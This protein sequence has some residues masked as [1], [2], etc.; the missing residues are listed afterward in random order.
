[1]EV[2]WWYILSALLFQVL[3]QSALVAHNHHDRLGLDPGQLQ[4]LQGY[5]L[6]YQGHQGHTLGHQGNQAHTLGHQGY[7]QYMGQVVG[8][9]TGMSVAGPQVETGRSRPR[10]AQQELRQY[11]ATLHSCVHGST[12]GYPQ[13]STQFFQQAGLHPG[14]GFGEDGEDGRSGS[15]HIYMEVDP[16]YTTHLPHSGT[17]TELLHSPSEEEE[18]ACSTPGLVSSNSSQSS[19][20]YSTAPSDHY[21]Y[22]DQARLGTA[23]L[24]QN[25]KPAA[26][27]QGLAQVHP[28]AAPGAAAKPERPASSQNQFT[29]DR[30][31]SISQAC[32][33]EQGRLE[34]GRLEQG[35]LDQGRGSRR[36]SRVRS[37]GDISQEHP[38][39]HLEES[40]VI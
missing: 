31:F 26:P 13:H 32:D 5:T 7:A 10:S 4:D 15:S 34:P 3:S 2:Y 6:G 22:S 30:V 21:C 38:L 12:R 18:P 9:Y 11:Q 24:F 28:G 39:I 16:L 20:G 23:T 19:S 40:Q 36:R 29:K 14:I 33:L 17:Q 1:M 25:L 27:H 35:R 8:H 37:R